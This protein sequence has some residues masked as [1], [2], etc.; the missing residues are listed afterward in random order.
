VALIKGRFGC[1]KADDLTGSNGS[2]AV[3]G[4]NNPA[5]APAAIAKATE[6]LLSD[7]HEPSVWVVL[8]LRRAGQ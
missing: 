1:P 5:V 7:Y 6:R 4:A 3:S 8:R 2:K